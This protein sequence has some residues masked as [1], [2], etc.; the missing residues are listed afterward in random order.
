VASTHVRELITVCT[1]NPRGSDIFWPSHRHTH[2]YL[3]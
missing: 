3:F 2:I 1:S